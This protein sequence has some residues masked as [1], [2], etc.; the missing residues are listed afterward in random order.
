MYNP[1]LF[2]SFHNLS[3]AARVT[4]CTESQSIKVTCDFSTTL[5]NTIKNV[6]SFGLW[7]TIRV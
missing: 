1:L 4:L 2:F 7:P 5:N 3:I 6:L